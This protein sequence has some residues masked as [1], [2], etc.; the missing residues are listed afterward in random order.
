[1]TAALSTSA[2]VTRVSITFI[3]VVVSSIPT[4]LERDCS[5]LCL[6][7]HARVLM[8][9]PDLNDLIHIIIHVAN[10]IDSPLIIHGAI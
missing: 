5:P 4:T 7:Q 1:M 10:L 3:F 9:R 6:E 8:I 2:R